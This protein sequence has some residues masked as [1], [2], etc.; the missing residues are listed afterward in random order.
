MNKNMLKKIIKHEKK[1]ILWLINFIILCIISIFING[2]A[3]PLTLV[4]VVVSILIIVIDVILM[5]RESKKNED[6]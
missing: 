6:K 5:I 4:C 1:E 2:K 3:R